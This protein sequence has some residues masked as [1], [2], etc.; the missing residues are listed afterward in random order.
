MPRKGVS[1]VRGTRLVD[2]LDIIL[3]AFHD[4]SYNMGSDFMCVS[5]ELE[6]CMICDNEDGMCC[7]FKQ[8]IPVL[9]SSDNGQEF[10]IIY[11]VAL[12]HCREGLGVVSAWAKDQVSLS[13]LQFLVSLEEDFS[14]C[15]L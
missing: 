15:I 13:V 3:L 11:R 6:V 5:V 7:T 4:I 12:F 10:P 1:S 8:V 9:K 14:C 2:E